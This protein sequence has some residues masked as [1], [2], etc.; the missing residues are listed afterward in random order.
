MVDFGIYALVHNYITT[1]NLLFP[2]DTPQSLSASRLHGWKVTDFNCS[3]KTDMVNASAESTRILGYNIYQRV[4][5][6]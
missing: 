5:L 3:L 6:G 4:V 1:F 2:G